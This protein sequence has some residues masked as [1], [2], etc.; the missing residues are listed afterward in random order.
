MTSMIPR[1]LVRALTAKASSIVLSGRAF[2]RP[3]RAIHPVLN[4]VQK[5]SFTSVHAAELQFGQP[6][7]YL[8]NAKSSIDMPQVHETH[9][10]LLKAGERT[11]EPI[12]IPE[13]LLICIYCSHSRHNRRRVR[14]TP[15]EA[16]LEITCR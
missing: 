4:A 14:S 13:T 7:R 2:A 10:H 12:S 9:P 8:T 3:V 15:L 16:S 11:I 5:R 6:V 1:L